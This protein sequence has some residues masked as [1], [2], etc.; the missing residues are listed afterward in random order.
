MHS[1]LCALVF[2]VENDFNSGLVQLASW[3]MS[4]IR[5]DS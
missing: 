3:I 2:T 4:L 5:D 1:F